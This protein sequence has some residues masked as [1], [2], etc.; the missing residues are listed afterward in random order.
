V[1]VGGAGIGGRESFR[2]GGVAQGG[3]AEYW[4]LAST[5]ATDC[6]DWDWEGGLNVALFV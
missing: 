5:L 1:E 6:P 4:N 3:Q 2:E